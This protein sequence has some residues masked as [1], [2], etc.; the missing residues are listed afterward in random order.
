[1]QRNLIKQDEKY[2]NYLVN[3]LKT[4]L[5]K[6]LMNIVFRVMRMRVIIMEMHKNGMSI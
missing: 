6:S 5:P 4:F 3:G 2:I 1:M